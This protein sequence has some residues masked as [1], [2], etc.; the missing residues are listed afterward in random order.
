MCS[1]RNGAVIAEVDETLSHMEPV[2][3]LETLDLAK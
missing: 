2:V 1:V 3:V